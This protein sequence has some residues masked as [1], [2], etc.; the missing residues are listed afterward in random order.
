MHSKMFLT[1]KIV[2]IVTGA[3]SL[4]WFLSPIFIWTIFNI[5]NFIGI[6]Y[7]SVL[8]LSGVFLSQIVDF[9]GN[10]WH[11]KVGKIVLSVV[12][13]FCI[14]LFS[15][16]LYTTGAMI[17]SVVK[18][19]QKNS[20]VVVLGCKVYGTKPSLLLRYRLE[21]ALEYLNE[22]PKSNAVLSGGQGADEDVSEAQC[23]YDYL[24][25]NGVDKNRLFLEDKS[26][27]TFENI[28]FSKE[29][30]E[31][32]GIN[33]DKTVIVTNSFHLYR[34]ELFAKKCGVD[35]DGLGAKS[36]FVTLPTFYVRELLGILRL[37][38]FG[39]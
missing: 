30:M 16:I 28:K 3:I 14:A 18:E 27:N 32:N 31:N 22:N 9:I 39:Y 24:V 1:F 13:V 17:N 8:I 4:L 29:I 20:T 37:Q 15:F 19:P 38:L 36:H 35:A 26:T 23:M 6:L 34:A 10:F 33:T 5:G 25:E 11:I 7:S 12:L 2:L 21:S